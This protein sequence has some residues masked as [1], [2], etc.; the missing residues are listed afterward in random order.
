MLC[1][2]MFQTHRSDFMFLCRY[3]ASVNQVQAGVSWVGNAIL[4]I[5]WHNEI[6]VKV[7]N[8]FISFALQYFCVLI[9]SRETKRQSLKMGIGVG[10]MA[11]YV[12]YVKLVKLGKDYKE[13]WLENVTLFCR[14]D[15]SFW[16]KM[17]SV[18]D[19][20]KERVWTALLDGFEKYLAGLTERASLIQETDALKQQVGGEGRACDE[21]GLREKRRG[22]LLFFPRPRSSPAR[23][24]NRSQWPRAWNGLDSI[25]HSYQEGWKFSTINSSRS[26]LKKFRIKF[27]QVP[28][29]WTRSKISLE[30]G[31]AI[32]DKIYLSYENRLLLTASCSCLVSLKTQL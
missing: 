13:T 1:H 22:P 23:F 29:D 25:A 21:R 4:Q 6:T 20:K 7:A 9:F 14:L 28:T 26:R 11:T 18:I 15:E 8:H 2:L 24:F 19:V 3:V 12:C 10:R 30:W 17:S 31:N 5:V 27:T 32:I 16:Q